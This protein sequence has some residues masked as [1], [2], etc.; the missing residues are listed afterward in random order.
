MAIE[1]ALYSLLTGNA[2][3]SALLSTRIYPERHPAEAPTLPAAA[4][5]VISTERDYHHSGQS[6]IATP[7]IQITV[8]V[9][10]RKQRGGRRARPSGPA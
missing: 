1:A 8:E 9:R 4:Y 7:R 5:Q 6:A 2:G 10:V 3:V